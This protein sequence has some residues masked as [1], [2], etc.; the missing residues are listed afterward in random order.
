L[1]DRRLIFFQI[2]QILY[3]GRQKNYVGIKVGNKKI[4]YKTFYKNKIK[5]YIESIVKDATSL[6]NKEV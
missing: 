3:K 2:F 5:E 1:R 6:G 4:E